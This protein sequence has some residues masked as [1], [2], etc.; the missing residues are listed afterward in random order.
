MAAKFTYSNN[1][2]TT[3]TITASPTLLTEVTTSSTKY[4]IWSERCI[5]AAPTRCKTCPT[6]ITVVDPCVTATVTAS[7]VA[8]ISIY[9]Y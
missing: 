5:S 6:D 3:Y 4:Q 7:S 8:P 9:F 2:L 1:D